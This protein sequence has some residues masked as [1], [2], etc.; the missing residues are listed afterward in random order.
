MIHYKQADSRIELEQILQLQQANLPKNL[1]EAE[2]KAQGFL[3]VAHSLDLL[4]KMNSTFPHTLAVE[5]GELAGYALSMHP[6]F[7]HEIELL[8]PMFAQIDTIVQ[9]SYRYMVMGQICVAKPYRGK[10]VFRGL[11][12]HMRCYV[13]SDF[14]A[15][16]TEVAVK[17]TR[18]IQ[19]HRAI[20][21]KE[22]HRHW[23]GDKEWS[24]IV[25]K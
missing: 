14:D 12:H 24:L 2:I 5:G 4:E 19:A 15:I 20:G 18:S 16:I 9:N 13:T 6:K 3:T 25:F 21:F 23:N 17:N 1:T 11:Y 10:G 22:I 8:K 7:A